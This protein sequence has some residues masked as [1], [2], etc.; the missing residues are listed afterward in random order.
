M[1][2]RRRSDLWEWSLMLK[3]LTHKALLRA[4][5]YP[6]LTQDMETTKFKHFIAQNSII[7]P[8]CI[9]Y[10]FKFEPKI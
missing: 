4:E 9:L 1:A 6:F 3:L 8:Y 5:N 7:A 2:G 10:D